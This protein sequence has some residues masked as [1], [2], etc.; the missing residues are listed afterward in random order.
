MKAGKAGGLF[1]VDILYVAGNVGG[2]PLAVNGL[3][4]HTAS[5]FG[6]KIASFGMECHVVIVR[7]VRDADIFA[8][9]VECYVQ[10]G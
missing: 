4:R 5:R 9:L 7:K 6:R 10:I 8:V 2:R 1:P 3:E